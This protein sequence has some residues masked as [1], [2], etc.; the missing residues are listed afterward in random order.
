MQTIKF[1]VWN[2]KTKSWIHGPHKENCL[3][4]CNLLG[5]TILLGAFLDGVSIEDLN[6]I[7]TPQFTGMQDETSHD[8]FEGDIVEFKYYVGDFAWEWMTPTEEAKNTE[9]LG[10]IFTCL[11]VWDKIAC[12]FV[13]KNGPETGA[14]V[15]FP[16]GYA[17]GGKVVGNRFENPE[18]CAN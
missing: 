9:M 2:N 14:H 17:R 16:M 5:E 10:K 12:S 11:V 1:R 7:E 13:L 3:D 15:T 4:G 6:E 18:L 8:V